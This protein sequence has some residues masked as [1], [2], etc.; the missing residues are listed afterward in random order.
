MRILV[1]NYEYPPIGGGG[2]F[3]TRDIFEY[4]VSRGHHVTLITSK[5]SNLKNK[6]VINGVNIHRVSVL[7]RHKIETASTA[8]MLSYVPST[9]LNALHNYHKNAFDIVNT[10]FAIPSG[11][12]G[13][14]IAKFLRIPNVLSIHGG[15][16]YDPSK[17]LSPHKIPLLSFAVE[18]VLNNAD[19]V[20]A[21]SQNTKN[22]TYKYYKFNDKIE[23]I[24]L[25]IK[26][27]VFYKKIRID[28]GFNSDD[29]LI[30]SIGR[31]VKRK[32]L[33]SALEIL[34]NLKNDKIKFIIIGEGPERN[35]LEMLVTKLG[36][37]SQ[38]RFMGNVSDDAKFQILDNSD[39]YFSS[40]LHEGFGLV[41]LEAMECG[42]PILCYDEGGQNDFLIN[43]KTGFLVKLN[44]VKSMVDNLTYLMNNRKER[45]KMGQFNKQLIKNYY[46]NNCGDNYLTLF[47]KIINTK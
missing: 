34:D 32:N 15:D 20:V 41:F 31:L 8:S 12:A 28:F 26:K 25:G 16:I 2:G 27:P 7:F 11:P 43:G 10:H 13:Y 3:V 37:S 38:V 18:F 40:A 44:D 6:E 4:I 5:Y 9:I 30:C 19:C 36:L 24:P 39:I 23:I 45:E 21:Q 42:L 22:N 17:S 1:V 46:I 35:R 47:R 14:C 33:D 29:F